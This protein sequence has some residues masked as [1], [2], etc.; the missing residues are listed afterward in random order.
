MLIY[1]SHCTLFGSD[2]VA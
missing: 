2:T 1:S